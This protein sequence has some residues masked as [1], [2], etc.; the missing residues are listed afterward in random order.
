MREEFFSCYDEVFDAAGNIK[1]CERDKCIKLI[2][3]AEKLSGT[4][5]GQFGSAKTGKINRYEVLKLYI[6]L[7]ID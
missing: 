7:N 2:K 3:V 5:F 4:K 1:A 6:S